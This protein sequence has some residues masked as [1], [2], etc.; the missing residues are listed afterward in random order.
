MAFYFK[1]S[2]FSESVVAEETAHSCDS[3]FKVHSRCQI[4]FAFPNVLQLFATK[5]FDRPRILLWMQLVLDELPTEQHQ[6]YDCFRH[7]TIVKEDLKCS[8]FRRRLEH[9]A[10]TLQWQNCS[11]R[12]DVVPLGWDIISNLRRDEWGG[13]ADRMMERSDRAP[14]LDW[15]EVPPAEKSD[16][17]APPTVH[18]N[19]RLS[20]P[21]SNRGS[22]GCTAPGFGWSSGPGGPA[23]SRSDAC[24]ATPVVPCTQAGRD[25]EAVEQ[26]SDLGSTET[27][28]EDRMVK[29]EEKD[30][31][32]SVFVVTFNTR[33]G[34]NVNCRENANGLRCIWDVF[35]ENVDQIDKSARNL[36]YLTSKA[37]SECLFQVCRE[38]GDKCGF[39][40]LVI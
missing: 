36:P 33:T 2:R 32:V 20:S 24:N 26:H 28:E 34:E 5:G 30:Q 6:I 39:L 10:K 17:A 18:T 31:I 15:E 4:R 22:S 1:L 11:D 37:K 12:M 25:N 27:L 29:W 3:Y 19:D 40:F 38:F 13:T 16:E 35:G 7:G 14:L 8:I 23:T 9:F 21:S